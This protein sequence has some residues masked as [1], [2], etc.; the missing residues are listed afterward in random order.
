MVTGFFKINS[1]RRLKIFLDDGDGV[2]RRKKDDL[3]TSYKLSRR[4]RK[5]FD[6]HE[7]GDFD[8]DYISWHIPPELCAQSECYGSFYKACMSPEMSKLFISA[9]IN[10]Q[11]GESLRETAFA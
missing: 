9:D 11:K 6:R 1:S 5:S 3:L 7:I 2:L 4:E 8:I 10:L